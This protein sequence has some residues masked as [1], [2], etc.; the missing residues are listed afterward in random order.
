M[1]CVALKESVHYV[2][3]CGMLAI[4]LLAKFRLLVIHSC[5]ISGP[6]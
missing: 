2:V 4:D 1:T 5:L 3:L 6:S